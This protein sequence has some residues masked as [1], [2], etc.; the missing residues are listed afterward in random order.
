MKNSVERI[1]YITEYITSYE[2]KIKTLN[3][4]GLF[5]EA[6]LFELFAIKVCNLWFEQSFYNLN[7][8]SL[9]YPG[10][11]LVTKDGDLFVQ[12]STQ[13]NIPSKV[14]KTLNK[15][16]ENKSK[17]LTNV[18][19]VYFFLLD[20]DTV[21]KVNDYSGK[22]RIGNIDFLAKK[23][24]ITTQ[25]II[26]RATSNL[27]FQI[28]LY[29]LLLKED[30]NLREASEN[31][32]SA[33]ETSKTIGLRDID[34][35][36]N[37][38]YEI[39][40]SDLVNKIKNSDCQFIS[41]RGDA[42][43]GK[44]AICKKVTEDEEYLLFSR[45]ERFLEETNINGIWHLDLNYALERL[46][47]KKVVFF[48]DSLEFIADARKTKFDLLQGLYELTKKYPNTKIITSC[49]TNDATACFKID[50]MY[51]VDMYYV[52]YLNAEQIHKI[53]QK[54]PVLNTFMC[55]NSYLDLIK[56]PFYINL[57][58][59]N[60]TD[61]TNIDNENKLRDFIW[62]NVICLKTKSN[63]YNLRFDEIAN[64][65]R[66]IVLDRAMSF[67]VGV[68]KEQINTTILKA[69]L[70]EGVVIEN[71][72]TVRLKYD[73][74]EDVCFEKIIDKEFD[75]SK[76]DYN[77]FF[78]KVE[79]FG[80]CCFR[81]YQI[82][83]SNKILSKANR[84]KFIYKL[85][86]TK[87][88]P[89]DWVKQTFIGLVKSRFCFPF[90]EEQRENLISTNLVAD[91]VSI[92]NLY[93]FET[94]VHY[95]EEQPF[96]LLAP[97]GNGRSALINIIYDNEMF[98]KSSLESSSIIKLCSDYSKEHTYDKKIAEK[99]CSILQYYIELELKVD[100]K[101]YYNSSKIINPLLNPIYQM[102]EFSREWILSFWEKQKDN[103]VSK[104]HQ[105]HR[106]AEEIIDY[107]L[108]FTTINL[109]KNLPKELCELA[110]LFWTADLNDSRM[111][112]G[113]WHDSYCYYFG[114]NKYA[115]SYEH[116]LDS[117]QQY[118]FYPNLLDQ[119]FWIGLKW[120]I[121]FIN[122]AV[123]NLLTVED[124]DVHE[125]TLNF[126][127]K[128]ETKSYYA[129]GNMW[130]AGIQE[131][132]VPALISDFVYLL[133]KK[134]ISIIKT[135]ISCNYDYKTFANN[136]KN[137]IFEKANN[138]I[139]FSMIEDIGVEF[140]KELP[141]YALDLATCMDF[142]IWDINR[143][144]ILNPNEEVLRLKRNI[145]TIM[146]VPFLKER[147]PDNKKMRFTLRDYVCRMQFLDTTRDHCY[148]ILDY[149]YSIYPNDVNTA[150]ENLQI[151]KMDM[152]N[153]EIERIDDSTLA[154]T[155]AISG[156]AKKVIED[157]ENNSLLQADI[158][159]TLSEFLGTFDPS[160]YSLDDVVNII[161]YLISK[162]SEIDNQVS[163]QS[164]LITLISLALSKPELDSK[165][166]DDYRDVWLTGVESLFNNG[167]F[168]FENAYLIVLFRQI[169]SNASREIIQRI[170]KLV[171]N[172]VTYGGNNGLIRKLG[173]IAQ[174]FLKTNS[175]LSQAVFNTIV[176]L[177][178]D[179]M[180]YQKHV[181]RKKG[182]LKRKST[183]GFILNRM[184]K[185]HKNDYRVSD[186]IKS[187]FNSRELEII[188]NYL[189]TESELEL[190][191]F[192]I[193]DYDI[194]TLCNIVNS[195]CTLNNSVFVHVL[196]E[197]VECTVEIFNTK[198]QKY[199][200]SDIVS[201]SSTYGLSDYLGEELLENTD[202][203]I[204]ILFKNIDFTSF[205]Y[206]AIEW[207][208]RTFSRLLPK[209]F[210]AYNDTALRSKCEYALL[211]LEEKINQ[212][213]CDNYTRKELYRALIMSVNGFEGDWSK[214][215]TS[216]SYKDTE[217]LNRMFSRYGKYNFKYFIYTINKMKLDKLLPNILPSINTTLD[218]F[219]TEEYFDASEYEEV[220]YII[221]NLIVLCFVNFNDEIKQDAD[222]TQ[223]Y[224]KIL[225]NLTTLN[226]EEA[227][228]LLDEFRIH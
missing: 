122:K 76:G 197:V 132:K 187:G 16:K 1:K 11:D 104:D 145:Q 217:F 203:V 55:D 169:D 112:Y 196:R 192:D 109:A 69:L 134:I 176:M 160:N 79:E 7:D 32:S 128:G 207:Y 67:S 166:R 87:D 219:I 28:K 43:C 44:S 228:V 126:L 73:I 198:E 170:E 179:E 17:K 137:Y 35:L 2:I 83:I 99:A 105:L 138:I 227:A 121:D 77:A 152:R 30:T 148:E 189:Y 141:G 125:I 155:P 107:T 172:L 188:D 65:V 117:A 89:D 68:E 64:E 5:D 27:D 75:S 48:I 123:S 143:F 182:R 10:V 225:E 57:I 200:R 90:F 175:K 162:I 218:A 150:N 131:Y 53:A 50:S 39:D 114:L 183:R 206:D 96:I 98:I 41:V 221:N 36:I 113:S 193:S 171:L 161:N 25:H 20:N 54:Y 124:T 186:D 106:L 136:V 154:I 15:V 29:E 82:W 19:E 211:V 127:M 204:D 33:L 118:R 62:E 100:K 60:I 149:L 205:S 195:G 38:E 156:E 174:R 199:K 21:S 165:N 58:V 157:R 93:A 49:R 209:Y 147:Y 202:V 116:S 47:D 56:T 208:Q 51:S 215:Q 135:A 185:Y 164:I 212:I 3:K 72:N 92:T 86:F 144:A 108:K 74:F 61:K 66:K 120:A 213:T 194:D 6:K 178:K 181:Y 167:S 159:K 24:L 63:Q 103:F 42:G 102:S 110:E 88:L 9:N 59:R 4:C 40:R 140:E 45:A 22:N 95:F 210:D 151:Q 46:S 180:D 80:R 163:Y 201:I 37:D 146:C 224:E 111:F 70:S 191:D 130:F 173:G 84:E 71:N 226:S 8:E 31:L 184:P 158:E 14:L 115:D 97:K 153:T 168:I 177:S 190:F 133:R 214:I 119:N 222:L 91:F 26:Q 142:I 94:K 52:E 78:R 12:V 81:R 85:I 34:C 13:Q 220:K 18:K 223:A 129:H 101:F 139:M 216:Y 23:H